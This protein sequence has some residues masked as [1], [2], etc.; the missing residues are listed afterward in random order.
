MYQKVFMETSDTRF[1]T[2]RELCSSLRIY[3][4]FFPWNKKSVFQAVDNRVL[5][6]HALHSANE[7]RSWASSLQH[8]F[9]SLYL[10]NRKWVHEAIYRCSSQ[11]IRS[12][13]GLL[14]SASRLEK[15]QKKLFTCFTFVWI[16]TKGEN[17]PHH[18][19]KT[20]TKSSLIRV[21]F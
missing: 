3:S 9:M 11:F 19:A 21:S 1:V 5:W 2:L 6:I 8:F 17:F 7:G 12:F 16:S 14:Q 18:N 10:R 20:P 13:V 4:H 15:V